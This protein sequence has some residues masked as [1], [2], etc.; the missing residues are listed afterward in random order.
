[1]GDW[2]GDWDWDW[3]WAMGSWGICGKTRREDGTAGNWSASA[4]VARWAVSGETAGLMIVGRTNWP[5]PG[6]ATVATS[7]K[8]SSDEKRE[9]A[10]DIMLYVGLTGVVKSKKT[11][12][13]HQPRTLHEQCTHYQ[14]TR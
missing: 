14:R 9:G 13:Q 5:S 7:T 6:R 8:P 3:D 4:R 12:D 11:P 1:M 10:A 2:V